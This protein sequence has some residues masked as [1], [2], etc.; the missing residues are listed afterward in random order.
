MSPSRL[1]GPVAYSDDGFAVRTASCHPIRTGLDIGTDEAG[2]VSS[3]GLST[4]GGRILF[5]G[6]ERDWLDRRG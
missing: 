2:S 1:D 4:S 3:S 5:S 6:P